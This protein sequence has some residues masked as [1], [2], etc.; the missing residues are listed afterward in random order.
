MS[1]A[2]RVKAQQTDVVEIVSRQLNSAIEDGDVGAVCYLGGCLLRIMTVEAKVVSFRTNQVL[3]VATVAHVADVATLLVGRIMQNPFGVVNFGLVGM[4][5]LTDGDAIGLQHLRGRASVRIVAVRTVALRTGMGNL[6]GFDC[7]RLAVMTGDAQSPYAGLS[8]HNLSI[9]GRLMAAITGAGSKG[10]VDKLLHQFGRS[11]FVRIMT[12]GARRLLKRLSVMWLCDGC[13]GWIVTGDAELGSGLRQV[14][15]KFLGAVFSDFVGGVAGVAAHVDGGVMAAVLRGTQS[16]V[17]TFEAEIFVL[18]A[19]HSLPQ[20][21]L[22]GG[23]VGVVTLE[24][25]FFRGG[26]DDNAWLHGVLVCVTFV[27][28]VRDAGGSQIYARGLTGDADHV[29]GQTSHI[30]GWMYVGAFTFFF[31]T[32]ETLR[33]VGSLFK[34]DRMDACECAGARAQEEQEGGYCDDLPG[35]SNRYLGYVLT[36][37]TAT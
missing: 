35:D 10:H 12:A 16:D 6:G 29:A 14:V 30:N 21:F 20:Q 24:A 13:V 22:I 26:M 11:G 36:Q 23:G 5:G 3:A 27:A 19:R 33:S 34:G 7:L 32:L 17:V 37:L 15:V 8:Q 31:V 25:I 4:A 18:A 9:L 1:E 2:F 28:E